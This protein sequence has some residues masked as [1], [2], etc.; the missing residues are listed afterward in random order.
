MRRPQR[1]TVVSLNSGPVAQ[2]GA[3][4][5][6][7]EEVVGSIPT[8]STK[9]SPYIFEVQAFCWKGSFDSRRAL[10]QDFACGLPLRSRPQN[11]SSSIPTRSTRFSRL[12]LNTRH[13]VVLVE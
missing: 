4:F 3:R 6:G 5:H 12:I 8:R 9:F 10:A 11:G 2:L 1:T 13:I 7:M